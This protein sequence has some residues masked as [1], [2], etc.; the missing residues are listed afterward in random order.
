MWL[1]LT[2]LQDGSSIIVNLDNVCA[3]ASAS[4]GSLLLYAAPGDFKWDEV[5]ET[6]A[7]IVSLIKNKQ[8]V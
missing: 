1:P 8:Y 7:D 2:K 4:T 6:P 5:K 3:I